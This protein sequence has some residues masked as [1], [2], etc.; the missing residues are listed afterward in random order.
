MDQER[1]QSGTKIKGSGSRY[2]CE[3]LSRYRKPPASCITCS[4]GGR[5]EGEEKSNAT[6][7]NGC[8]D[9]QKLPA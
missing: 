4:E 5:L 3:T 7:A 2:E 8:H 1:D 9:H 6:F